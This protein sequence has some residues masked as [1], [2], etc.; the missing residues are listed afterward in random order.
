MMYVNKIRLRRHK[1]IERYL[2]EAET[3]VSWMR[4]QYAL[5][6]IA[7]GED[8]VPDGYHMTQEEWIKKRFDALNQGLRVLAS[9]NILGKVGKHPEDPLDGR[10]YDYWQGVMSAL[11]WV[12][13]MEKDF[14]DT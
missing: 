7:N 8:Q 4:K 2:D 1:E 13:G 6:R 11:R 9:K 14:L 12:V 10:S 3:R 5:D